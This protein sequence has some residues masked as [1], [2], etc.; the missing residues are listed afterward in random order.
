MSVC[1]FHPACVLDCVCLSVIV[2]VCVY[3]D[4]LWLF[5]FA[6]H[7]LSLLFLSLMFPVYLIYLSLFFRCVNCIF[8]FLHPSSHLSIHLPEN[9]CYLMYFI[10]V[11]VSCMLSIYQGS[12][13]LL[14]NSAQHF[15][16]L[17]F[18][19][20]VPLLSLSQFSFM[21]VCLRVSVCLLY[22]CLYEYRSVCLYY[23][24]IQLHT[25]FSFLCL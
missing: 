9:T 6:C 3:L 25:V 16:Y 23:R 8:V 15:L 24:R 1:H 10:Y 22:V 12:V 19:I 14:D 13:T 17:H 7:H 5:I 4:Q 18:Q 21:H 11:Y 20:I 2:C